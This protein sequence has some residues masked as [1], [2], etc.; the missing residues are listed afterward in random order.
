MG[1]DAGQ[2]RIASTP[3]F[4]LRVAQRASCIERHDQ[5]CVSVGAWNFTTVPGVV[6]GVPDTAVWS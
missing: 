6:S 5:L 2:A 4:M 1:R 3:G